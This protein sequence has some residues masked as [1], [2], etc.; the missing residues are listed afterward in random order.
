MAVEP[1]LNSASVAESR[2]RHD[3][4]SSAAENPKQSSRP[5]KSV[6][7]RS[8]NRFLH[9]L[10]RLLPGGESLRIWLHRKR[11]VRIGEG[12]FIGDD[13]Y[14]ENEYPEAVEIQDGAQINIRSVIIAHTRGMG[15]V[16]IEKNVYVGA[17][18]I[19]AVSS[20]RVLTIGEGSVITAG[21]VVSASVPPFTLFGSDKGKALAHITKPLPLCSGYMDFVRGLRPIASAKK[22]DPT[23]EKRTNG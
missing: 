23:T 20:N 1:T 17:G 14:I 15:G 4:E 6:I 7:R 13:V 16:V 2:E 10:S 9:L 21:S 5:K 11:G 19:I 18:C 3:S 22:P 8:L 12:V